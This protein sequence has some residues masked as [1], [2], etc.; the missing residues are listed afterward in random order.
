[1]DDV[2]AL[3]AFKEGK[4]ALV[5][6]GGR[7]VAIV[8]WRDQIYAV[9]ARCPHMNA[10]LSSGM[11]APRLVAKGHAGDTDADYETPLLGC[12]WHGWHFDL[13][14]GRAQW[15]AS[16]RIRRYVTE[17]DGDRVRVSVNQIAPD[18]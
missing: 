10:L 8:K 12:P 18:A 14:T 5:M 6:V 7:E 15:D 17:C 3:S 4:P 13:R 2:G 9:A 1:M 11:V 16:C